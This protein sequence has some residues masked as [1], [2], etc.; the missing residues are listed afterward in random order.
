MSGAVVV[1]MGNVEV[2]LDDDGNGN[3]AG[4]EVGIAVVVV[5]AAVDEGANGK[6]EDVPV[7]IVVAGII[8]G[9]MVV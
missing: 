3:G 5:A 2:V 9:T 6:R 7:F 8:S 1:V 4:M